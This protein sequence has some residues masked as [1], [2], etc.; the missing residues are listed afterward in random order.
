MG[1]NGKEIS[2]ER[3]PKT[4]EEKRNPRSEPF[5]PKFHW[6]GNLTLYFIP[7]RNFRKFRS[8]HKVVLGRFPFDPNFRN[9][10]T[11]ISGENFQKIWKLLKFREAN[12]KTVRFSE[13]IMSA[14]K[15]PSIFSH[16]M[17]TIV[18]IYIVTLRAASY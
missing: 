10:G 11:E 12:R 15:Y 17:A 8:P 2:C 3:F 9:H 6:G 13:Q 14:D 5:K 1:T 7:V 16:Q 4:P 18:Y